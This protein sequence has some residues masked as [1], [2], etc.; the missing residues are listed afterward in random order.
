MRPW[1]RD[2]PQARE[3][4]WRVA[5]ITRRCPNVEELRVRSFDRTKDFGGF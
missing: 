5:E 3:D 4:L 1:E 2:I